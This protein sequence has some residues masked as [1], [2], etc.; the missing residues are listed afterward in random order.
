MSRA[1]AT[2]VLV[3]LASAWGCKRESAPAPSASASASAKAPRR[4][5][6]GMSQCNLGEPWRV[7]MNADIA[8]AA[9][10]HPELEL[11]FKDAQNDSLRQRAQVE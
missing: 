1:L 4:Y 8:R 3:V 7:Q 5:V 9:A 11:R 10:K 6:V 2:T